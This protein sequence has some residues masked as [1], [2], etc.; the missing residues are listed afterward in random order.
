MYF[1]FLFL[2][3]K[4]RDMIFTEISRIRTVLFKIHLKIPFSL[5]KFDVL[6]HHIIFDHVIKKKLT[7]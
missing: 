3:I 7:V 4:V 2:F 1:D 5:E 6:I